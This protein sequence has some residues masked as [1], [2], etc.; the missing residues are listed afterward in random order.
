M[1]HESKP[2]QP[3]EAQLAGIALPA[4]AIDRD[5]LMYK[6][7]WHAAEAAVPYDDQSD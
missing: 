2:S 3:I 4:L 7:G 1:R 5:R 6:A